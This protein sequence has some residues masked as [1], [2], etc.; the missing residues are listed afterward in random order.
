MRPIN[1]L[2]AFFFI[3]SVLSL[4]IFYDE[5][6]GYSMFAI[7]MT[8]IHFIICFSLVFFPRFGV[9]LLKFYIKPLYLGIPGIYLARYIEK[10]IEEEL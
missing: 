3:V 9:K 7:L 6:R 5:I 10:I 2:A 4:V 1:Y 8:S